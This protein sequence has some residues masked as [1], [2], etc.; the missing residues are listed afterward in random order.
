MSTPI[1]TDIIINESS[2][3]LVFSVPFLICLVILI[4]FVFKAKC[5]QFL[6]SPSHVNKVLFKFYLFLQNKETFLYL[7]NTK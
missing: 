6:L 2:R 5:L 1:K 7:P 4:D 3:K